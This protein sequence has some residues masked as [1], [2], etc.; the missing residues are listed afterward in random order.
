M[1]PLIQ[2]LGLWSSA[3]EAWEKALECFLLDDNVLT[4]SERQLKEQCQQEL[5]KAQLA[6]IPSSSAPGDPTNHTFKEED[7]SKLAWHRAMDEEGQL[8]AEKK[9]SSVCFRLPLPAYMTVFD[10]SGRAGLSCM[11]IE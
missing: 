11:H 7:L 10:A 4:S 6:L 2:G 8:I 9:P 3:I 5:Q 1:N